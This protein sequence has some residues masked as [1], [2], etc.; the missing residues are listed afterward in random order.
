VGAPTGTVTFLFTDIEGSTR[1]WDEHPD[2]MRP[3]LA[4]HDELLRSAIESHGGYV[5]SVAGDGVAAG[6]HRS[7]DAVMAAVEAQRALLAELWPKGNELRVRMGLHTGE[8]EERDGNYFGAPLNRAARLMAAAHGGQIVVSDLTAGLLGQLPGIGLI[9]LGTHRLRGLVEPTR[10]LGVKADGLDWVDAPLATLEGTGGNLPRPVTEWFGPM[11]VLNRRVA[12]LGRRRLVTL[13]G[14]GGVGKTRLAIEM[15]GLVAGDFPDGVWMVELAPVADPDA[16]HAAVASTLGVLSQEGMTLLEA[17]LDWLEDRRLL[18]IVDNCEH[19]L[20]AAGALVG[21]VVAACDTVRVIATSREPLGVAGEQVVPVPPL[22]IPDAVDLFCDRARL[23]DASLEFPEVE[24]ETVAAICEHLDGIPLAIE[25]AA[26]RARSLTPSDL[27][28]LL[29]NRFKV[30]RGRGRGGVERHQTLRAA[31]DWSYQLLSDEQRML[32]DRLSLFA[33]GFDAGAAEAVCADDAIDGGDVLDL[34]T[35]LVDKSL[36]LVDRG[37]Q[38]ARYRLLETLRQYG[39]ERL[40]QRGETLELRRR[41]LAYYVSVARHAAALSASPGGIESLVLVR[42]EWDNLRAAHA[43]A[44]ETGDLSSAEEL[45]TGTFESATADLRAEYLDWADRTIA[46]GTPTKR[47]SPATYGRAASVA[48]VVGENERSIQLADEGI[49]QAGHPDDPDTLYCWAFPA[50][51]RLYLGQLD[52]VAECVAHLEALLATAIEPE[53]AWVGAFALALISLPGDLSILRR[54]VDEAG[55]A[56]EALGAPSCMV[57]Y[58][59]LRGYTLQMQDPPDT[60][61]SLMWYR[62]SVELARRTGAAAYIGTSLVW[63][64]FGTC[65]LETGEAEQVASEA[66][67]RLYAARYAA[68]LWPC[69][70]YTAAHLLHRGRTEEAAVLT[71]HLEAHHSGVVLMCAGIL[72]A[73]PLSALSGPDVEESKATGAAMDRAEL[74]GYILGHLG[75][76]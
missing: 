75:R 6:F 63:L 10:V 67:D 38:T 58:S 28:Q 20:V 61:A 18:L 25:L 68:G 57:L 22:G 66:I 37:G 29:A 71:G 8:A 47:A 4:R 27:L 52:G 48:W 1:L 64:L 16:V 53:A 56:A 39:E 13:T 23:S 14:P 50:L 60:A 49:S 55:T 76:A 31:V 43:T 21:S 69:L 35:D 54:R 46:L 5:F 26:A 17:I 30:L 72:R 65:G 3:A 59:Y 7:A 70:G 9:D 34:L 41:H 32:F 51:A 12:E 74:V 11:A 19:V 24:R 73:D 33:G 45:L 2:A 36:V 15:G 62:R 40:G 44:V 42:Q